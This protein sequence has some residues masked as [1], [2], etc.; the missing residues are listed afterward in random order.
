MFTSARLKLTGWYLL[1]VM[2]ISISFSVAI[3]K[4]LTFE[5]DRFEHMQEMRMELPAPPQG[6]P[7]RLALDL[8]LID[9]IKQRLLVRL[10]VINA[11]IL[12]F[13]GAL[14]FFLAS[15]T[16]KPIQDMMDEQYQFVSDASH[17]LRTPL[18]S[19]KSGIEVHLRD[20]KIT[21][22]EAKKLM[23]ENL[24]DVN[25]LELLTNRLLLLAQYEQVVPRFEKV[26]LRNVID[27]AL[28][29]VKPNAVRKKIKTNITAPDVSLQGDHDALVELVTIIL[30]NAVKYSPTQKTVSIEAHKKDGVVLIRV[31]DE[32]MGISRSDL[33]HI[34]DRF[35]RA[36]KARTKKDTDGFGLGLSIAK[37]IAENHRG[38]IAAQSTP[39]GGTTIEVQVPVYRG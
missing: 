37:R 17:E 24:R 4:V 20:K 21:L 16:L 33:P 13:S 29:T 31:H 15:K 32:G 12:I 30:D 28:R 35:Y 26:S 18:T 36:D 9:E 1:I 11:G 2:C 38:S 34:F 14:S 27:A 6:A 39:E 7:R 5:L 23:E 25:K 3:Y 19:L 8:A 10:G 22:P